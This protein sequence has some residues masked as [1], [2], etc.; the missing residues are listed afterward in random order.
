MGISDSV[1]RGAYN[2]PAD[3]AEVQR[4]LSRFTLRPWVQTPLSPGRFD[5]TTETAIMRFQREVLRIP[6]PDGRIAPDSATF[7]A[8]VGPGAAAAAATATTPAATEKAV[9]TYAGDVPATVRI[10]SEYAQR[11]IKRALDIAGMSAGV[12]TST[13]R[14]P[15][16]Q[17]AIMYRNA[18]TNLTKQF[19]LYGATGDA[20]LTVYK[21]NIGKPKADVIALMQA[22]IEDLAKA[23]RLVSRHCTTPTLYGRL[24]VVDIGVNSTKAVAGKTYAEAA[25]T[26]AFKKLEKDGYIATFIDET[27]K[28]NTCWHV[29]IIPDAKKL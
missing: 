11:V 27:K 25:L 1:G 21:T 6:M 28:S 12:M 4:L 17:A 13:L 20:V 22:K 10:V 18:A 8:L 19:E 24:N 16:E 2:H 14:L 29:E 9:L 23:G 3:V 7:A 26:K 5:R 15:E